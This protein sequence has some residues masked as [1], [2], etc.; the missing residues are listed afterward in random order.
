[1][2]SV[3]TTNSYHL[4]KWL[5]DIANEAGR[6]P[7][8]NSFLSPIRAKRFLRSSQKVAEPVEGDTEVFLCS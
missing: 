5:E 7:L 1:M 6:I 3:S 8:R 2:D 4:D